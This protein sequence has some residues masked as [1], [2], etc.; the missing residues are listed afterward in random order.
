MSLACPSMVGEH[1]PDLCRTVDIY[2]ERTTSALDAEP[3]NALT[4]VAFLIAAGCAWRLLSNRPSRGATGLI[5]ALTAITAVVGL[6][7][8][9]FHTVATRWAEWADVIPIVIFMLLFLWFALTYFF[10]W[11]F[12]TKLFGLLLFV[13]VTL[14]LESALP[15]PILSG[16]ALYVPAL[17][18]LIAVGA[19][20]YR[21]QHDAGRAMFAAAGVFVLSFTARMLDAPICTIFPLGTHFLWHI[22]NAILLYLLVRAAILYVPQPT[23]NAA[24]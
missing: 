2:C 16:G 21:R 4:N 1:F 24:G 10:G 22:L 19:A 20:L 3:V 18:L 12:W 6:G 5:R 7:S 23:P 11:S 15:S 13:A 14:F 8:F 17:L 9:L